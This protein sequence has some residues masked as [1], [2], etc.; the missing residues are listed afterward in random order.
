[1]KLIVGLGNPGKEYEL[2]RHNTGFRT[3]D[4]IADI[5]HVS[6]NKKE[7]QALTGKVNYHDQQVVLM[8][9]Q[10]YMNSSGSAISA[11]INYYHVN[12]ADILVIYDDLDL[13]YGQLRLR[14]KGS[15]GGH[16]G[17]KSIINCLNTTEFKRIRVG[18]EKSAVIPVVDYVL[19][20]VDKDKIELYEK[21]LDSAA[22][23]AIEFIDV[24][25]DKVMNKYNKENDD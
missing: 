20:K 17:I 16:N 13:K 23:A 18:I 12:I 6:V 24:P 3:I 4:R 15:A 22:K 2:T 8:K 9:P 1:M 5:L 14:L 25:F 21:S 7:C 10:T 19:G 11:L